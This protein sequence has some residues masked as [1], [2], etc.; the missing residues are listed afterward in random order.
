MCS[1]GMAGGG[2]GLLSAFQTYQQME[3]AEEF[4]K[5]EHEATMQRA[6]RDR[7]QSEN[8]LN[9]QALENAQQVAQDRE[10]LELETRRAIA[11]QRVAGAESGIGGVS[12]LRQFLATNIQAGTQESN[13]ES[14]LRNVQGRLGTEYQSVTNTASDRIQNSRLR[15]KSQQTSTFDKVFTSATT[16]AKSGLNIYS[17]FK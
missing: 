13:I 15:L 14:N 7:L 16:G 12:P 6:K 3:S 1:A 9:Q 4:A 8:A 5:A 17:A 2:L 10:N 11:S